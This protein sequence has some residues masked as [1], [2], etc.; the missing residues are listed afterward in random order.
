MDD[1][2][3]ESANTTVKRGTWRQQP[4]VF[5]TL[6]P[7]A[8][9]PGA[10]NRYQREYDLIR[11]L[12]SPCV[13]QPLAF[14]EDGIRIIF[15]DEGAIALRDYLTEEVGFA[16]RLN[17]AA[18]LS[19]ALQ[20]IHDE[21]VIH[22]DINPSNVVVIEGADGGLTLRIIDFGLATLD[23]HVHPATAA[24]DAAISLTGTLPYISPEQ[25]GRVN[26]TVD[27][28]TDLYSL[29]ATLYELF[30]GHPPFEHVDPLEL[31]HAHIASTSTPLHVVD[32]DLPEWLGDIVGRL[33]SK[34]P[35]KRYQSAGSVQHDLAEAAQ[36]A[37]VVPFRLG[38]TD[39]VPQT[40]VSTE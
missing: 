23:S 18:Q 38:S 12:T 10:I 15:A 30:C 27:Y 3:Y 28:R 26:R 4:A 2:L 31:I 19:G 7:H 33:L 1:I 29:G 40:R 11:S 32:P 34:Q 14:D 17:I 37:N 35:E 9:S 6:K 13:C 20:S 16:E 8:F 36:F 39:S 21:G 5:K 25:T 22:R 24:G